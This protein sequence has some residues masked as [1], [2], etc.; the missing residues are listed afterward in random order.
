MPKETAKILVI[1]FSAMGDVAMTAP[2][3][4][5]FSEHYPSHQLLMVS[6][7]F[8]TPF[9]NDIAQLSFHPFDPKGTHKGFFGLI[10]LFRELNRQDITAIADLHSNLRSKI[11][12][13]L[14]LLKGIKS[15]SVDKGRKEKAALTRKADKIFIPLELTVARY[16]KVFQKLGFPFTLSNTLKE[17]HP[18]PLKNL[19]FP[20]KTQKWIGVSPFAQHLQKVY[21]L[22]KM[23][24]V[25][26][27]LANLG[28][29]LF[30]FGG[31]PEEEATA[32]SW[33][34]QH[35]NI[36]S[37]VRKVKLDEELN[38]ISNLDVMLSMDSSGMH[39]ASL[40]NIPV[41]S[42]WGATH[43]YAGF[44]GYGQS[45]NDAVQ[46]DLYCRPCAVYGNIPC[47]RGDFACMNNLTEST[48][49][50]SVLNKLIHGQA[51][52]IDKTRK[53]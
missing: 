4:K 50:N 6:R 17:R 38:L 21:P 24:N 20:E 27:E 22:H 37:L 45:I 2:I 7:P 30:I 29:H 26:R 43:P 25:V 12:C 10:K 33:A 23:E 52:S 36:T 19:L 34:A 9:F 16:A 18:A 41:V 3:L 13:F 11:L 1:R 46:I 31:S 8:F 28:H 14:F 51:T 15:V 40:K 47:Y 5:E 32:N 48:V 53:I 49:I 44:L 35:E 39:L 42:V